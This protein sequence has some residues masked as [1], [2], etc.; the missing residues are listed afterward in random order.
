MGLSCKF[1][2]K[3]IS[4][5]YNIVTMSNLKHLTF[6]GYEINHPKNRGMPTIACMVEIYVVYL[7][8]F[9]DQIK[10]KYLCVDVDR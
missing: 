7:D 6:G 9:K 2:L 4:I 3:P 10:Y 1:S 8:R 5:D